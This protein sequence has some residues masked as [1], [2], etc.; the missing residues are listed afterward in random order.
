[1][2]F[3]E[4]GNGL[5]LLGEAYIFRG[6]IRSPSELEITAP[7]QLVHD[8]SRQVL[9][10]Q[11]NGAA[12][13]SHGGTQNGFFRTTHSIELAADATTEFESFSIADV[14]SLALT[15]G[16]ASAA[17]A[18]TQGELN[19]WRAWLMNVSARCHSS[20]G[21]PL[22]L[23]V[24]ANEGASRTDGDTGIGPE[25]NELVAHFN[26]VSTLTLSNGGPVAMLN[27]STA[28]NPAV[29][30]LPRRIVNQ[31]DLVARAATGTGVGRGMTAQFT[32]WIGLAGVNA[33]GL[34]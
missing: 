32:W 4:G 27:G 9:V 16:L 28:A 26:A 10:N 3:I 31:V 7:V 13:A 1:M 17:G 25:V 23:Y 8:V 21:T 2:A 14:I 12:P 6:G 15:G 19:R 18:P 24:V 34:F 33:P 29:T 30:R 20:Y 5:Q 22:S 11:L